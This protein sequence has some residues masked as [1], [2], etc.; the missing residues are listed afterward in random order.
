MRYARTFFLVTNL[1]VYSDC[2]LLCRQVV[3]AIPTVWCYV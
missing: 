2:T 1:H 3:V